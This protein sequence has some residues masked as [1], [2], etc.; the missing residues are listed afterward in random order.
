MSNSTSDADR[1]EIAVVVGATG[2]FGN[3]MV[4]R[5]VDAGLKVVAVARSADSL[6][7]LQARQSSIGVCVADISDDSSIAAIKEVLDRP[8]RALVHGP[9]VGVAGGILVAPTATMV[10]AVN[11]KV[12]GLLRLTRAADE[13]FVKGS[14]IIA[15]GGHYGLE[16]TAYAASA[17]VA[18]AALVNVSRQLSLAYGPRGVTAHVIA[19]GPA[20][21]ERLRNVAKAR[22]EQRGCSVEDVLD[23]LRE[24]SSIGAFTTP[25]Q[26]AWAVSMLLD[27]CADAMTGSTLMLDSGRRKGLP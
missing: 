25:E 11:I 24:E 17:G 20:D 9:G 4:D 8:V 13:R 12:G 16:P 23:E 18:N 6:A 19:P 2:A 1:T 27:P 22:A 21:T 14:R 3:K 5:L 26:V 7:E 10:D 15:I